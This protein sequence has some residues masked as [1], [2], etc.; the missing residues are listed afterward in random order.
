M[1]CLE[2]SLFVDSWERA[3]YKSVPSPRS[4]G[5]MYDVPSLGAYPECV[6]RRGW[7]VVFSS[8]FQKNVAI[9]HFAVSIKQLL[10]APHSNRYIHSPALLF[11]HKCSLDCWMSLK[12]IWEIFVFNNDSLAP[13]QRDNLVYR[14]TFLLKQNHLNYRHIIIIMIIFYLFN[15][16]FVSVIY[17]I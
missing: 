9:G 13:I 2:V 5:S 1:H 17:V 6:F 11:S 12:G 4:P 10:G 3:E 7:T 16:I 14:G 15:S 8:H